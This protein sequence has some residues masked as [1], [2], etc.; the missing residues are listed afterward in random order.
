MLLFRSGRGRNARRGRAE[1]ARRPR[2]RGGGDAGR[3]PGAAEHRVRVGGDVELLDSESQRRLEVSL[4]ERAVRAYRA[5]LH[6]FFGELE[7]WAKKR[8]CYYGRVDG[9]TPFEDVLVD[10]LRGAA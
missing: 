10:Y 3:D 7:G 1:P 9:T 2:R 6:A 4:D 5:R 8:G